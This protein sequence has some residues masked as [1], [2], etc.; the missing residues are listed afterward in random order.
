VILA[1]IFFD[2]TLP[3]STS[4]F[5]FSFVL[6]LTIF[7]QFTRILSLRNLDIILLFLFTPGF[8]LLQ[9]AGSSAEAGNY[10]KAKA[11]VYVGYG[12]LL[13]ITL[14]WTVRAFLDYL[15]FRRPL[16]SP[17][18]TVP[19]L[20]VLGTGLLVSLISVAYSRAHDPWGDMG[21]TPIALSSVKEEATNFVSQSP[22]V[23]GSDRKD[24]KFWVERSLAILCH[25]AVI[26]GLFF[27][28][29]KVF[30]DISTG[31]A[32]AM[33]Y[34]LVPGTAYFIGQLH[35]VWPAALLVWALFWYRRPSIAGLL[36]GISAG[37]TFFPLLLVPIWLKFYRP[38]G[39]SRFLMGF[40][41]SGFASLGITLGIL[42]AAG[43]FPDGMW[44]T[45][46]LADWQPWHS[47]KAESIWMGAHWAYRV[48]VFVL[49]MSFV[50]TSF[51]WPP[52]RNLGHLIGMSAAVLMSIQFWFG[53]R[54]GVYVLWYLPLLILM[55]LRPNLISHG[56]VDP[57][58]W[59]TFVRRFFVDDAG[60]SAL[61]EPKS[62]VA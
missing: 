26:T 38:H 18:L 39:T 59:P 48:P 41:I 44:Q 19:G 47:P 12:W 2:L 40:A 34:L 17:N 52:V 37:T 7:F 49:S 43:Q 56:P 25:A 13:T 27:V 21:K 3:N 24:I 33:L 58:P 20:V 51:F 61:I 10:P 11:L 28:G 8:L 14:L 50:I 36:L 55:T 22:V 32:G 4:W 23:S 1:S 31:V 5:Y 9:E 57:G 53:D 46:H 62:L 54:G 6:T 60:K 16:I 30:G 45:L 42:A 35:H 15:A 29:W